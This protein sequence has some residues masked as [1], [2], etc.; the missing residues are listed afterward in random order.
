MKKIYD[1]IWT[2]II[3]GIT[4]PIISFFGMYIWFTDTLSLEEYMSKLARANVATNVYIWSMIP[5]FI[6]SSLLYYKKFDH[7][8]KGIIIPTFVYIF[9]I[10]IINF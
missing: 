9:A 3:I 8:L 2:G 5:T 6:L 7:S 4:L 1:N 10:V